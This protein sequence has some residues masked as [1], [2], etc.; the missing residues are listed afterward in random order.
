MSRVAAPKR[1]SCRRCPLRTSSGQCRRPG[2]KSGRCGDWV[3]YIRDGKQWRRLYVRPK[4]PRTP[5]QIHCRDGFGAA[6]SNYSPSLTEEQ[7]AACIAAGAKLR[8]R[9][10]L[11]QSGPLTGQQYSISREWASKPQPG[12]PSGQKLQKGPQTQAILVS[13]SG[14]H[15]SITGPAPGQHRRDTGRAGNDDRRTRNEERRRQNADPSLRLP[16]PVREPKTVR[17]AA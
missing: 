1:S 16:P 8:S 15:R 12:R 6:A 3:W 14:Q 9:P 4:D 11:G 10:R 7:R 5:R 17:P 2:L 13:S